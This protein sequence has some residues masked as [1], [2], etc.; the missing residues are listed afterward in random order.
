MTVRQLLRAWLQANREFARDLSRTRRVTRQ[1]RFR[2]SEIYAAVHG[3]AQPCFV[4]STGRCGTRWLAQV[5]DRCPN[6]AVVHEPVPL[7]SYHAAYAYRQ[8]R[9][10]PGELRV[11]IDGARYELIRDAFLTDDRYIETGPRC[12]FFAHEL[13]A[14]YP[15]SR[16][17]HLIR[18]PVEFV[19]SGLAR[20][21]YSDEVITDESRIRPEESE[22]ENWDLMA[23]YEKIAWLWRETNEFVRSF[24]E[25]VSAPRMLTVQ[26]LDLFTRTE[27]MNDITDF[28]GLE[29]VPETTLR[30]LL[31]RPINRT[32]RGQSRLTDEEATRVREIV[33]Q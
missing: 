28:A 33:E 1:E 23:Q 26:S 10:T 12:T 5:L 6:A 25:S 14:L 3:E 22:R 13:A 29:R 19:E 2:T 4:L 11:L 18:D 8:F 31:R 32:R 20:R 15:K 24:A 9:H 7:L 17:M 16:F 21:W 27:T 30:R